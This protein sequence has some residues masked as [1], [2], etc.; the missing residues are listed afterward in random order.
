MVKAVSTTSR[1]RRICRG[2][3]SHG[4]HRRLSFEALEDRRLLTASPA[5]VSPGNAFATAAD[6]A[7]WLAELTGSIVDGG[8]IH[9]LSI[10]PRSENQGILIDPNRTTWLV[11]HGRLGAATQ[12]IYQDIATAVDGYSPDD[13]VL[14]LD[15]ETA[16][17]GL[18]AGESRIEPV[19]R[20]AAAALDD[21]GFDAGTLNL[22]GYSWGAYVADEL[23]EELVSRQTQGV[24]SI[25]LLD[26]AADIPFNGYNPNNS[27]TVNFAAH[28][29]FSWA[30]HAGGGREFGNQSQDGTRGVCFGRQRPL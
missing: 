25:L 6:P 3:L 30:F 21:Y 18:W 5:D 11:I 13:Q 8:T 26:P 10:A 12:P 14:L 17:T 15:W 16:A 27:A 19:G 29:E 28:S 23:A 2:S 24:N 4:P 22:L 7:V 1:R 9:P 20:W